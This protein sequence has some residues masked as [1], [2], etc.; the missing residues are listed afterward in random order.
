MT[1]LISECILKSSFTRLGYKL[2]IRNETSH[3]LLTKPELISIKELKERGV[4]L[5]VPIN[6]C[7]KGHNL[8]LFF[9]CLDAEMTSR[10][11]DFGHFKDAKFEAIAKVETIERNQKN[12]NTVFI[13]VY[14]TQYD[15]GEWQKILNEYEKNQEEINKMIM[16]QHDIRDEE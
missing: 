5:E 15:I 4:T 8:T 10:L 11:P 2:L 3:T 9:I 12:E 14:F 13:D 1:K 7:Q 16:H 6:I